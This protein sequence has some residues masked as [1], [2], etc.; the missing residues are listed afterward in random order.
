MKTTLTSCAAGLLFTL[1]CLTPA[2]SRADQ[3]EEVIVTI[4][5]I[6]FVW[7][8]GG[9]FDMG[10]IKKKDILAVPAHKVSLSDFYIGKFEVTFD[11]YDKFCNA[12]GRN[13]P[14]DNGLGRGARPVI[15]VSWQDAIDFTEWLSKKSGRTIRLPSESEWEFTAR[16]GKTTPYWW[17]F[18]LTPGMANCLDCGSKWD[19]QNTAPVGSFPPNPYGIYDLTGNV[20]EWCQDT[21]H[22]NYEGAPI[23][24]SAWVSKDT[25]TRITRGGSW[26]QFGTE[27][28][29]FARSWER[30][31]KG[32]KDVG[33]RLVLEP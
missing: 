26:Q 8:N 22:D 25:S 24:N 18:Q 16:G 20:Y 15:N 29:S 5:N 3:L 28:R 27:I 33:F 14:Q 4:D 11:Q 32:Y 9:K 12:T 2:A 13:K 17:G 21:R 30:G 6:Q 23:D 19:K 1:L 31:D 10:D 7:I